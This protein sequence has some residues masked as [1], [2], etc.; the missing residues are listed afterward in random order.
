MK[1]HK[2]K[3][4]SLIISSV[5]CSYG[6]QAQETQAS[7]KNEK[8]AEDKVEVIQ[9]T[10]LKS[11]IK[12]SLFIKQNSVNVVDAIVAEDIGK[13]PDQ[14]I[15]E[16][17]Q[18]VTGITITRNGGE[19]QNV[20]VRGLGGDYNVATINGRR[21]A[22]EH[23]S[24]NFNYDLIAS[25][26]LSGVDVYKSPVAR[27]QEGG[28]GSVINIKTRRPL[29]FDGFTLSGSVKGIYE[30]RV[31]EIDPQ[32][33]FLIS[34]TF[35]DGTFGALFTGV[36]SERTLRTDR[37]D[38]QGF[39]NEG[40]ESWIAV[41]QDV[42]G[43][44]E[45]DETIDK[46]YGSIIPG[47]VRYDNW[48]DNRERI[49]AS[50]ALQWMPNDEIEMAFDSLYSSY[51][52]DGTRNAL[53]FVTYDESW[54][55]GIPNVTNLGFN[56]EGLVNKL[57]LDNGAMAEVI[58]SST[59]R[60]TEAFQV[61]LNTLWHYSPALVFEAD[62]SHSATKNKNSGDNR[63]IVARGF[64]K[65]VTIDAS[66]GNLLPDIHMSEPLTSDAP[67]GAHYSYNS[68]EEVEDEITEIR[69]GGE[70]ALDHEYITTVRFGVHYG[71]QTKDRSNFRSANASMFSNGGAY[72]ESDTYKHYNPDLSSAEDMF[73]L[74]LFR[75]PKDV[76]LD[77]NFDNFL[78]GVAGKHPEPWARFDYD[79]LF[80]FYESIS[81]EAANEQIKG[82]PQPKDSFS[83]SETTTAAFVEVDIENEI[84]DLP[85][86]LNLGI[87]AVETEVKS[88]G[89]SLNIDKVKLQDVEKEDDD[90]NIEEVLQFVGKQEQYQ[91]AVTYTDSYTDV[92]PSLNFKLNL[93]D[94]LVYR[95]NAAKVLTRPNIGYLKAWSSVNLS[96]QEYSASSPGLEPMRANQF[97]TALEW[98][99]SEYGALTTAYFYKDIESTNPVFA[100]TGI[101]KI[102][103]RDFRTKSYVTGEYGADVQGLEIAYQQ[104]FTELLPAPFDGL[105]VQFNYTYVK[106]EDEDPEK[107]G[108]PFIRMPK[109]SYN[110]VIYYEKDGIQARLAYNWRNK[111]LINPEEWGGA[112]WE[113]DYG[114]LDFSSSYDVNENTTV[115]FSIRNMTNESNW[116]YVDRPEQVRFLSTYGRVFNLGVNMKF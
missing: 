69:L 44:G 114:Q 22:S 111:M 19:G 73:G 43:D 41:R 81:K 16:A 8:K 30:D 24:R 54:T 46:E 60:R 53:S 62:V 17:L 20:I 32:A 34:D 38:G 36:Y 59:P 70:W 57:T 51:D 82:S 48:Q 80:A 78:S 39:Y 110:A 25:E 89:Y 72:F 63:F 13:F 45:F 84:F 3:A 11:S 2:K 21:M 87:R 109:N 4:L 86:T 100:E 29:D 91:E 6:A 101:T 52:T 108:L 26:L 66:S 65:D 68:G 18:R 98:Y 113:V 61:G 1:S 83:L 99:F 9:V 71:K 74:N 106:S 15:A 90:G 92:L 88:T 35:F 95:F 56:D 93:R 75:L 85:F 50:L 104:A 96:K 102:D 33:S 76:L 28:I 37:Y 49:G 55:P 47:Y 97:D 67:F 10:G 58:N 105:G 7:A 64:V 107:A 94:D 103:G 40:N 31:Q 115:N 77:A 112:S 42:D 5:L 116:H 14:N 12:E 79:K 23:N 27:T